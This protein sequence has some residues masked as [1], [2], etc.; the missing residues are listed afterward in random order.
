[1]MCTK[2]MHTED[3][4]FIEDS[5][6]WEWE[7]SANSSSSSEIGG[8]ILPGLMLSYNDL[9]HYLKSFVY[10]CI[11]PKDYEIE[12]EILIRQ[13]VAHGLIEEKEGTYV[14]VTANQ[15]I[16]DLMNR[17][18]IEETNDRFYW[19]TC[20]KLHDILHDLALY[21]S[22][23]EYSHVSATEHT[24][25]L[26]LLAV[27]GAEVQKQTK[28]SEF[29]A[30]GL[31]KLTNLR[32]LHR[33]MVCD[34]KG[35]T[36]R[37][38]MKEL[39]DLN[40][41]T[42][43]LSIERFGGGRV[44]VVDAKKAELKE[45]HEL[46]WVKFDFEA[47]EDDKVGNASEERGLLEALEPPHGIG[48]LGICGYKGDRPT[49]NLDTN[50]G[51]LQMLCLDV[52]IAK[53]LFSKC[54]G[55]NT[56]GDMPALKRLWLYDLNILKQLPTRLPSLEGLSVN[57][58][59]NCSTSAIGIA[60]TGI[61]I[62]TN[63]DEEVKWGRVPEWVWGFSQLEELYVT[64]FSEDISLGGHWQCLPKL[65]TLLL[66]DFPNLKSLVDASPSC[67]FKSAHIKGKTYVHGMELAMKKRTTSNGTAFLT[68]A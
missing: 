66:E 34:D 48:R 4:K 65:R 21:I 59:P 33:F 60:I 22:G 13:W 49:W 51:E 43:E 25:N 67:K 42:G 54:D 45:K 61:D 41:L 29:V 58:L 38:N 27:D 46:I 8:K 28:E 20:L 32:T 62:Y 2:K 11:Y 52:C 26:S 30:E 14:E 53:F 55:L 68:K 44:K 50:Y 56:I 19:G 16:K 63:V 31:G 9:L 47:R 12:R 23:K 7:M 37:W 15:Y 24:R 3:W 36:R 57:N 64:S 17:C 39:K 5:K 35:K 10:C 1:M 18:L 40:K 6:I